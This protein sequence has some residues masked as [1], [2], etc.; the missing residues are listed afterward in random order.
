[1]KERARSEACFLCGSVVVFRNLAESD[2]LGTERGGGGLE[3]EEID[4]A[5]E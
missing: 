4:A 5:G 2:E 3:P 1:M